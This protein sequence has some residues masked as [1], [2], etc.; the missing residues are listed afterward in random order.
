MVSN[1]KVFFMRIFLSVLILI[2]SFQSWTKADDIREFEI[3]GI[4][5]G[6]SLLDFMSENE[7][8][9]KTTYH[10]EQGNDKRVGHITNVKSSKNYHQV[11][12]EFKTDDKIYKIIALTGFVDI[13]SNIKKCKLKK[14]EIVSEIS[15]IFQD[16]DKWDTG[17]QKH[18]FDKTS[19]YEGTVFQFK[20]TGTEFIRVQC[21][22]WS[23]K[24]GYED[25]LRIEI[26]SSDFYEWL[27]SLLN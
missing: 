14:K 26:V 21:Y 8:K 4:S 27:T 7:I 13:N 18:E 10:N 9:N 23:K 15:N 17:K 2:L 24:S 1:E 12:A 19:T 25:Q 11:N 20:S 5:I 22:D 3:E 16:I 6:D